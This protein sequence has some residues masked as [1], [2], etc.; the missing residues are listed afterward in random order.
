MGDHARPLRGYRR[1]HAFVEGL[2][3]GLMPFGGVI[4]NTAPKSPH[5][6]G[7][8]GCAPIRVGVT[9]AEPAIGALKAAGQI[10]RV[11]KAPI[12]FALLINGPRYWSWLS[13]LG[14]ASRRSWNA[15]VYHG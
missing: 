10:V 6:L 15:E 5:T 2:K 8:S 14:L 1:A 4:G 9:Y 13:A 11:E 7:S 3:L 12:L